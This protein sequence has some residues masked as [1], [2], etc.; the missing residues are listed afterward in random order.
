MPT[1]SMRTHSLTYTIMGRG[2]TAVCECTMANDPAGKTMGPKFG[3]GCASNDIQADLSVE[4][5]GRQWL[6]NQAREGL[7]LKTGS[8]ARASSDSIKAL[9]ASCRVDWEAW[10]PT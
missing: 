4:Q 10:L 2:R 3:D 5:V 8:D 9:S 7:V 6:G 1:Q